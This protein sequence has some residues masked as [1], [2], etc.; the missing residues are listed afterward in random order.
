[1]VVSYLPVIN[2]AMASTRSRTWHVK[3]PWID[4]EEPSDEDIPH[5]PNAAR[6]WTFDATD[7]TINVVYNFVHAQRRQSVV[8]RLP[9]KNAYVADGRH[10]HQ[11][12]TDVPDGSGNYVRGSD[13]TNKID[14]QVCVSGHTARLDDADGPIDTELRDAVVA[15]NIARRRL[16]EADDEV[17]RCMKHARNVFDTWMD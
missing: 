10:D 8:D 5:L 12:D 3:A 4:A 9:W 14:T 1:M 7:G 6:S 11:L 13:G 16:R 17:G 2:Y 15:V